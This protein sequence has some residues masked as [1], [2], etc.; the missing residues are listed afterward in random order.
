[1]SLARWKWSCR[2]IMRTPR[3]QAIGKGRIVSQLSLEFVQG[4]I[5]NESIDFR[6]RKIRSRGR[7]LFG[8]CASSV[9][10]IQQFMNI[11]E[12]FIV[13]VSLKRILAMILPS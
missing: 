1:M 7:R 9:R 10:S 12:V 11:R 3:T 13:I 6:V 4:D 5:T 8:F 2:T